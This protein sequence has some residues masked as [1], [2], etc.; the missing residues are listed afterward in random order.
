[1]SERHH[2]TPD[3]IDGPFTIY[4]VDDAPQDKQ[5]RLYITEADEDGEQ[6]C[7]IYNYVPESAGVVRQLE[8]PARCLFVDG[9]L[10]VL[11]Q[12][13]EAE[14]EA[15]DLRTYYEDTPSYDV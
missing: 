4:R 13:A 6:A 1:M 5:A 15:K 3:E 11:E 8:V 10:V 7:I 14:Q 2:F 12:E 9:Y